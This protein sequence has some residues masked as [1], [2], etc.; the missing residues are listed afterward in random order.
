MDD[1]SIRLYVR[2]GR[3][4]M[5]GGSHVEGLDLGPE[6]EV[7]E[8]IVRFI[9][10]RTI[11]SHR[12]APS[13]SEAAD[14]P[15][16]S[17]LPPSPVAPQSPLREP[18]RRLEIDRG[19]E[20]HDLTILGRI[21]SN[22]GPRDVTVLDLSE[23]GCRF[24]D[25]YRGLNPGVRITIKLGPIGPIPAKVRWCRDGH[26]GIAFENPLYPSVLQ[27]IRDHFDMRK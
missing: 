16:R 4:W 2:D 3:I 20:R 6:A 12:G 21:V 1:D 11:D 23:S 8:A 24:A 5:R 27:H 26:V 13:H 25:R 15:H 7:G 10:E 9:D 18:T 19:E 17:T 22:A 14:L